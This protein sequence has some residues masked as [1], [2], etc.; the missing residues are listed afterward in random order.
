MRVLAV[1]ALGV[2]LVTSAV[3]ATDSP[4]P[5]EAYGGA[6]AVFVGTAQAPVRRWIRQPDHPPFTMK[7]SPVLVEHFY[8]GV[9]THIVYLTSA[10]VE[11]YL[12]PGQR[13]L[14]YGRRY[15]EP[16]VFMTSPM[17]GLKDADQAAEHFRFL[18]AASSGATISGTLK[19]HDLTAPHDVPG[20]PLEGIK[21]R[22]EGEDDRTETTT[23]VDGS[24]IVAGLRAGHYTIQP[25]LPENLAVSDRVAQ[26]ASVKDG[27]CATKTLRAYINGRVR[28]RILAPD[29]R[30]LAGASVDLIPMDVAP[31]ETGHVKGMGSVSAD[32]NGAF[33]F[34]GR[35]PGRYLLGF[36]LYNG[37][38]ADGRPYPRTYYPGTDD[39]AQAV[40]VEIGRGVVSDGYEF[41]V[42]PELS[43]SEL[44]VVVTGPLP[45]GAVSVILEN[46]QNVRKSWSTNTVRPGQALSLRVFRGFKYRV[47]AHLE[48]ADGR[49]LESR[50]VAV[51]ATAP[52]MTVRLTLDGRGQC[53]YHR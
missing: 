10:G 44:R 51:R 16:D 2:T 33:E 23:A 21:I 15:A 25:E 7:V 12:T 8:R 38:N 46:L 49:Y 26:Q 18:E 3:G 13:Y 5:C 29:K 39:I 53:P 41:E 45:K 20:S 31:D 14:V 40:P 1:A 52:L 43:R 30:P 24:F 19:L 50:A 4:T 42:G 22:V 47:H 35:P 11:F 9:T 28:G 6:D 34:N 37:P 32:D 27:G 17:Y 36:S 48:G